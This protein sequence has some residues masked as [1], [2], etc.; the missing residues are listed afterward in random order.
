M[1]KVTVF[2]WLI[3]ITM[4]I[5]GFAPNSYLQRVLPAVVTRDK[6]LH[7][8]MFGLLFVCLH[9]WWPR[10]ESSEYSE[11]LSRLPPLPSASLNPSSLEEQISARII[12]PVDSW[13][14]PLL[15]TLVTMVTFSIVSE[16]VQGISPVRLTM[17]NLRGAL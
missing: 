7:T 10:V 1:R 3:L 9:L 2:L 15:K 12:V 14:I 5:L 17:K 16:L 8:L 4:A 11:K 6:L 13:S